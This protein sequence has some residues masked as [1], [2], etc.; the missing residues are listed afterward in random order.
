MENCTYS[1]K[2]NIITITKCATD[3]IKLLLNSRQPKALGIRIFVKSGGCSGFSYGIEYVDKPAYF[4]DKL[5][6]QGFN[7]FIDKKERAQM[8]YLSDTL[9]GAYVLFH[10]NR[11]IAVKANFKKGKLHGQWIANRTDGTELDRGQFVDGLKEGEWTT[12]NEDEI[13]SISANYKN[14]LL[15][16]EYNQFDE[17]G[18]KILTTEY[19]NGLLNGS[20]TKYD[21]ERPDYKSYIS[22]MK[23]REKVEPKLAEPELHTR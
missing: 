11:T 5:I 10:P 1:S 9:N 14:G 3:K 12:K 16:G 23:E 22:R 15:E 13:V 17:Y 4:D 8:T 6:Y 7:I 21:F 2:K 18:Y 20:W 19:K